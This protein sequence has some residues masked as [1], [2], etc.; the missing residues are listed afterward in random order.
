MLCSFPGL[1]L[2]EGRDSHRESKGRH[3]VTGGGIMGRLD[4]KRFDELTV[5]QNPVV[6]HLPQQSVGTCNSPFRRICLC[7]FFPPCFL[8]P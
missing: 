5:H 6:E 8:R 2:D 7:F 4:R 1:W 3:Q